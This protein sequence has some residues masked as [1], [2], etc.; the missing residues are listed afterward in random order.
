MHGL[1]NFTERMVKMN[2]IDAF[3]RKI[4]SSLQRD[5]RLTNGE[6]AEQVGLSASQCSRRRT[7]LEQAGIV[8][9]YSANLEPELVGIGLTSIISVTLDRHDAGHAERFRKL[10]ANLPNV[11]EAYA[12]TGE[13]DY[14]LKVVSKD[15]KALSAFI[16]QTLLPH[17][18]VQNV[19]TAIVLDT[20]KSTSS[21]PVA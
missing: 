18:A 16:N 7:S 13:M 8:K 19:K 12:L 20:L 6:L 9:G 1:C 21:L 11:Q 15:L 14:S 2:E 10:V 3:D 4:L 17:E 5:G